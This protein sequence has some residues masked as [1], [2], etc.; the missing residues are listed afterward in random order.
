MAG[1]I[2]ADQSAGSTAG[3]ASGAN[4][5]AETPA[6]GHHL[7]RVRRRTMAE[8]QDKGSIIPDIGRVA[9][10]EFLCEPGEIEIAPRLPIRRISARHRCP[11]AKGGRIARIDRRENF[12]KW[13][14][15]SQKIG[16]PA[17]FL[18][19]GQIVP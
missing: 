9:A 1:E 11:L 18:P 14:G 5:K 16:R 15:V 3:E 2:D 19:G 12:R 7:L 6:T 8:L 17:E 4:G 13:R 10:D